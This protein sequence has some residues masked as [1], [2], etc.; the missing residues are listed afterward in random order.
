MAGITS[1][2]IDIAKGGKSN[3]GKFLSEW[4]SGIDRHDTQLYE[5]ETRNAR[6]AF[7]ALSAEEKGDT[8]AQGLLK[9]P[10]VG[11][12]GFISKSM[13]AQYAP[14]TMNLPEFGTIE[15]GKD[16]IGGLVD[17]FSG[18]AAMGFKKLV[19]I[20]EN[21]VLIY[22]T[23]TNKL[24][25]E[26]NEKAMMTGELAG[27]FREE[28]M[29]A[30]PWAT[31][32]GI[33][34]E[35]FAESVGNLVAESGKFK[36]LNE[37]TMKEMA[38]ASKFT[39]DMS[40]FVAMGKDFERIGLGVKDM[41]SLIEKMSMRSL[42]LGLNG[43]TTV[44]MVAENLKK[45][46]QYGFK[47]G[48]DG[49]AK[50]AQKSVE[51]RMNMKNVFDLAEKVWSPDKALDIVANL[52]VIGG[53]FGDL[54]DPIKLMY[55]ATNNVEG[56]QGAIIGATKSLVTY[57]EE[58]GRFQ[59]TGVQLRMAKAM[60]DEFGMSLEELSDVAIAQ[61][62][63]TEAAYDLSGLNFN[64]PEKEIEFLTNL[65]RMEG[66]KM[67][68]DIPKTLRDDLNMGVGETQLALD[69]MTEFQKETILSQQDAFEKMDPKDI[70]RQQVMALE[71]IQRDMSALR[72]YM[73]ITVGQNAADLVE[74]ALGVNGEFVGKLSD[75]V[76]KLGM[77]GVG[78]LDK[79]AKE[80][81]KQFDGLVN[82]GEGVG[83]D[84]INGINNLNEKWSKSSEEKQKGEINTG[85]KSMSFAEAEKLGRSEKVTSAAPTV[86]RKIIDVNINPM[87]ASMDRIAQIFW[88]DARWQD[89]FKNSFINPNS[90]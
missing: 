27:A 61:A 7:N 55:M 47:D 8:A 57:N 34:F 33:G 71:N 17:I 50:M 75:A 54:N 89:D 30:S 6:A 46:N 66:G 63:R 53:A 73:R 72:G 31:K 82:I 48:V 29:D 58:Q 18:R 45:I 51:F 9:P 84:M 69:S 14:S 49:L 60:A 87:A 35:E 26:I 80:A 43:K 37:D 13:A 22:L 10:S 2:L 83:A 68:I 12:G 39:K 79:Y 85:A 23:Q 1:K 78:E 41:S 44:A 70:P 16:I 4:T 56:L 52:Q 90:N 38:L 21:E 36:L 19:G 11:T 67:I 62:E 5:A 3:W 74:K 28:I 25:R 42:A 81:I 24:F 64:I 32:L 15:G 65:A 59:V 40:T 20:L 88:G 76:S 77:T 86:E